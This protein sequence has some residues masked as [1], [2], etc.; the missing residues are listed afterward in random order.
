M[1]APAAVTSDLP[2]L[3][4]L[5][6]PEV[7]WE[8]PALVG[9]VALALLA[10]R[11]LAPRRPT[12]SIVLLQTRWF[13]WLVRQRLFPRAAQIVTL[14]GFVGLL[15]SLS[16]PVIEGGVVHPGLVLAWG[17]WW[18]VFLLSLALGGRSWCSVCP[19][20]FVSSELPR[21]GRRLRFPFGLGA[22]A[23]VYGALGVAIT[24]LQVEMSTEGTLLLLGGLVAGGV[25]V[26][27]IGRGYAFC[28]SAC[29]ALVFARAFERLSLVGPRVL[30]AREGTGISCAL[31][32]GLLPE[33][34]ARADELAP[35][36]CS[37]CLRCQRV[38]PALSGPGQRVG[39]DLP[40]PVATAIFVSA[41]SGVLLELSHSRIFWTDLSFRVEQVA[42]TAALSTLAVLVAGAA[43]L[44]LL[45]RAGAGPR[46]SALWEATTPLLLCLVF[47][48]VLF[49]LSHHANWLV[50]HLDVLLGAESPTWRS[51][52]GLVAPPL[53][54]PG[55]LAA[56]GVA[57]AASG[58]VHAALSAIRGAR[59]GALPWRA[60]LVPVLLAAAVAWIVSRPFME[61]C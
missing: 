12:P 8:L 51:R 58:G 19:I 55:T 52:E 56:V 36:G 50:H 15:A 25:A 44:A 27:Q 40:R 37:L 31:A 41:W 45:G 28:R 49:S 16:I 43:A 1:S 9:A 60:V 35:S 38:G 24:T 33:A 26:N 23:L 48:M 30:P 18:N 13:A 14:V 46:A 42:P 6:V 21:W 11:L 2:E 57:L 53:F 47:Y 5:E 39:A 22:A 7:A 3:P 32:G 59:A 4:E 20:F 34:A 54:N 61:G 17:V 29:P 10:W